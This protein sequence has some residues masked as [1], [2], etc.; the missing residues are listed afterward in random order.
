MY[1]KQKGSTFALF[2][3][4]SGH[5]LK[6]YSWKSLHIQPSQLP[7]QPHILYVKTH[8]YSYGLS[9]HSSLITHLLFVWSFLPLLPHYSPA[10]CMAFPATPPSLLTCYLY[11]LFCHSSKITNLPFVWPFLPFLL[12]YSPA[13]CMAFPATLP[14][15]LTCYLYG[16]S[17]HS[18]LITHLLFV[19][20][21]L[22]L[23]HNY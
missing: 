17:C 12:Y 19:W 7:G 22:P 14:S 21:F 2:K 3:I 6:L 9:C 5:F 11:G 8:C 16:L 1:I 13:I 23:V 20:P 15:L 18:S 4:F 10:I